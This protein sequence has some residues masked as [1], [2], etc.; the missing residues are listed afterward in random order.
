MIRRSY[1][2]D[3]GGAHMSR[4]AAAEV[5]TPGTGGGS[6][7][8]STHT[9]TYTHKHTYTQTRHLIVYSTRAWKRIGAPAR[10]YPPWSDVCIADSDFWN[11]VFKLPSPPPP[12][13]RWIFRTIIITNHVVFF[14]VPS[15]R[16]HLPPPTGRG[17]RVHLCTRNEERVVAVV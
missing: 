13:S 1:R 2:S 16:G 15:T 12:R 3:I 9:H 14:F 11:Y 6:G 7:Q 10:H 5:G 4:R 8:W 17:H